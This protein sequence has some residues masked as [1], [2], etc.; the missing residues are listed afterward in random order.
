MESLN[1]WK[2]IAGLGL[3]LYGMMQLEDALKELASRRFKLFLKKYTTNRFLAILNGAFA[4]AVLQSSSIVLLMVIGFAGA[5]IISLSNSLG[6]ILGA[7][8]GTTLTGWLVSSFGFNTS[9]ESF[10]MPMIGVGSL[11]ILFVSRRFIYYHFFNFIIAVGLLFMGLNFLK[12]G[13]SQYASSFEVSQLGDFG[14]ISYFL[15]GMFVTAL[16]H[17]S[18]AMMTITLGA[19]YANIINLVPAVFIIIGADLGTT[20]TA[21]VASAKGTAVK[22]RVGLAHFTFNLLTAFLA[23]LLANP[24][25]YII[26]NIFSVTDPLYS[27]VAFHTSFNILGVIL[28]VPFLGLFEKFLNQFFL[29]GGDHV[30]IFIHKVSVE[31]PEAAL[32]AVRLELRHFVQ[33]LVKFNSSI[34]GFAEEGHLKNTGSG[35]PLLNFLLSEEDVVKDYAQIKKIEGELLEYFVGLQKE[36]LE[37]A[38]SEILNR[39][40]F[41]LR[42]G[43]QSAK[44]MKDI[45][46]NLSEFHNSVNEVEENIMK[47]V[48]KDY[49]TV[50]KRILDIWHLKNHPSLFEE[51]VGIMSDNEMAYQKVNKSIYQVAKEV[52]EEEVQIAT[53]LNVNREVYNANR[54][55][56]E[57]MND[58]LLTS[59][60]SQNISSLTE[61]V[62]S[63]V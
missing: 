17:S 35:F 3:F 43:V 15:F 4:T 41:A 63:R 33:K 12:E 59:K 45:K 57:A 56:L 46:H 51:L 1:Y 53:F 37:V 29:N 22:K 27:L 16:L 38:E 58:I 6:I 13:M 44:S 42:K 50:H 62:T 36:K 55:L 10:I 30:C 18:S 23:I 54:Q 47:E 26:K 52:R 28:F 31:V 11:G 48:N 60:E 2:F 32:E 40:I 14:L 24:I 5:G 19:L 49:F 7:N 9:L 20:M 61:M 25:L 21:L 8:I 34:L 39:Y